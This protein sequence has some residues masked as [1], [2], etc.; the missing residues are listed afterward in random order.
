MTRLRPM[1]ITV[2]VE[3]ANRYACAG[4]TM[5]PINVSMKLSRPAMRSLGGGTAIHAGA[6]TG[7]KKYDVQVDESLVTF[8]KQ[9][10]HHRSPSMTRS[11]EEPHDGRTATSRLMVLAER[12]QLDSLIG[13]APGCRNRQWSRNGAT[14]TSWST[15]T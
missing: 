14:W 2:D 5:W 8:D 1:G 10:L 13:A 11:A 15:C 12:L 3:T 6:A 4:C 9:P 7:E